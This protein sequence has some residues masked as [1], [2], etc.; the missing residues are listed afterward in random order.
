MTAATKIALIGAGYLGAVLVAGAAVALHVAATNGPDRQSAAG[1][2]AFG[3]SLVFLAAFS[4]AALPPT[5]AALFMLR[6]RPGFWRVVTGAACLIA[7]TALPA[8]ILYYAQS[9]WGGLA[10]LRVL[11]APVLAAFWFLGALC[12]PSRPPR[13]LLVAAAAVEAA[14]FA[15]VAIR[16]LQALGGR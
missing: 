14:V 11:V 4:A 9:S 16:W 8:P 5:A 6:S 10:V 13:R 15:S 2:F 12:A 7:A 1:M 3:D